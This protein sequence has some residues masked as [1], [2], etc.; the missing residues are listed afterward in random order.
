MNRGL[1]DYD[2]CFVHPDDGG[3]LFL[4]NFGDH[5]LDHNIED[6]RP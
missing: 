6:S 2:P 4:R 5:L 1:L 3:D